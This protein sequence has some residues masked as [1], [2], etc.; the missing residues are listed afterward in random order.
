MATFLFPSR[1]MFFI[2]VLFRLRFGFLQSLLLRFGLLGKL[3][4]QKP[5]LRRNISS[6]LAF[7]PTT[8]CSITHSL[9]NISTRDKLV[10]IHHSDHTLV[11][12]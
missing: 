5:P 3:L 2:S 7:K 9:R 10:A 4:H 6:L 1:V 8:D 11:L 12:P